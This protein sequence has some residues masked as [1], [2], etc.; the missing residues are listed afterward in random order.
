MVKVSDIDLHVIRTVGYIHYEGAFLNRNMSISLRFPSLI[1][2]NHD[3]E[4][5]PRIYVYQIEHCEHPSGFNFQ[6]I[7]RASIHE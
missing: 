2:K 3:Q 1:T 4:T 5:C 6:L 7:S